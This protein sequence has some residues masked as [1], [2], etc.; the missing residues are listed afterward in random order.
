M[1]NLLKIASIK[2]SPVFVV[3]ITIAFAIFAFAMINLA[4]LPTPEEKR[5]AFDRQM[6]DLMIAEEAQAMGGT[7]EEVKLRH[8]Q[9]AKT[10]R[11]ILELKKAMEQKDNTAVVKLIGELKDELPKRFPGM[12]RY[13][14]NSNNEQA[15]HA[16][17]KAGLPCNRLSHVGGQAFKEAVLT[18]NPAFL[19]LLF[20][21]NCDYSARTQH[22]SLENSIVKSSHPERIFLLPKTTVNNKYYEQALLNAIQKKLPQSALTL[23]DF[24]INPNVIAKRRNKSAL[25]LSLSVDRKKNTEMVGVAMRLIQKGANIGTY[26]VGGNALLL[27]IKNGHVDIIGEMLT[28]D[29]DYLQRENLGETAFSTAFLYIKVSE[30]RR[31]VLSLLLKN[32]VDPSKFKNGGID[33][34]MKAVKFQDVKLVEQLLDAGINPNII[35]NMRLVLGVAKNIN[36]AQREIVNQSFDTEF[37]KNPDKDKIKIVTLLEQRGATN[38]FLAIVRKEK[39]IGSDRDC[40]YGHRI[41]LKPGSIA[42]QHTARKQQKLVTTPTKTERKRIDAFLCAVAIADCTNQGFG[43]DDCM[44]SIKTCDNTKA[45]QGSL[46]CTNEIQK[47]YF[48]A[49]CSGFD[50]KESIHWSALAEQ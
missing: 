9:A 26:A 29:P 3:L 35:N 34:L 42:K 39:G 23:L 31:D 40:Q 45:Y 28:R 20:E 8:Q 18:D 16:L 48:E 30:L 2:L 7:V 37:V 33:W 41:T 1:K 21:N 44:R 24:G 36:T 46:C 4:R 10:N 19:Q 38:D 14:V 5:Q 49:R 13:A 50:V 17:L 25:Y 32:G 15:F 43:S 22:D 47:H 12:F 27:A 6:E 11:L